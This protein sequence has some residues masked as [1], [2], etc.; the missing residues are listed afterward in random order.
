MTEKLVGV[1]ELK[2]RLSE[3]LRAVK[4]GEGVAITDRNEPIARLVPY[5]ERAG[6]LVIRE[7]RRAYKS[8]GAVPLP[9][10]AHLDV[11]VVDVL[12]EERNRD[13]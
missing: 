2:A 13:R 3:Y 12:L 7:P 5:A 8:L 4:R 9:P 1:A 11:D 10:P 6:R